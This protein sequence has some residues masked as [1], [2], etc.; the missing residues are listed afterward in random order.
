MKTSRK[1]DYHEIDLIK[2]LWQ[3][4]IKNS[5]VV[6]FILLMYKFT[7]F[8]T[9]TPVKFPSVFSLR[10]LIGWYYNSNFVCVEHV[11]VCEWMD[12]TDSRKDV[13]QINISQ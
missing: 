5:N 13:L 12:M 2:T 10:L 9:I 7:K 8:A 6:L 1:N 4:K 3:S 11:C